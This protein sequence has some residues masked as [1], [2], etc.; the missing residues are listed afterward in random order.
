M[1]LHL[2]FLFVCSRNRVIEFIVMQQKF[3]EYF[4]TYLK[5]LN[6]L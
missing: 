5:T 6:A 4:N 3:K 1:Y 2:W